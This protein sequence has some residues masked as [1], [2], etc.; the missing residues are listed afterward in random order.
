[1]GQE[2]GNWCILWILNLCTR[3]WFF[4]LYFDQFLLWNFTLKCIHELQEPVF[5]LLSVKSP[6]YTHWIRVSDF[7]FPRQRD[8]KFRPSP[9]SPAYKKTKI[10]CFQ[11]TVNQ[12]PLLFFIIN[13]TH[14]FTTLP[15]FRHFSRIDSSTCGLIATKRKT[16]RALNCHKFMQNYDIIHQSPNSSNFL[17]IIIAI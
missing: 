16:A 2:F 4:F 6:W 7:N 14:L 11:K 8:G 17:F 1:M 12:H 13:D 3:M 5:N 10:D 9:E 15:Y